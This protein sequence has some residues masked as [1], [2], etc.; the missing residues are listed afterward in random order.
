[1]FLY[2]GVRMGLRRG[3]LSLSRRQYSSSYGQPHPSSHP[4]LFGSG[5]KDEVTP[6]FLASEFASRR[7]RLIEKVMA[8]CHS[9]QRFDPGL[10]N[11]SSHLIVIPSSRRS[12]MVEKIP[13]FFRQ[14]SDFRYFT[15]N[16]GSFQNRPELFHF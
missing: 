9:R 10:V 12:Y 11:V 15:G 14:D 16:E 13:Y 6:G 4:H 7:S 8:Y 2:S 1:M 5:I 3:F